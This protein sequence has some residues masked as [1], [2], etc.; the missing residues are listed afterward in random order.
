M[1][2]LGVVLLVVGIVYFTVPADNLP[3]ILGH[4]ANST[5]HHARR[6]T[7]GVAAGIVFLVIAG[8]AFA[9]SRPRGR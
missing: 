5:K 3:A 1:L 2:V 6:G 8:L 7:A 4:V 9:R